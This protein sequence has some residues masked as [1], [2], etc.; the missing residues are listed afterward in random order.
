MVDLDLNAEMAATIGAAVGSINY[1]AT[2][3][4]GTNYMADLLG[5]NVGLGYIAVGAAGVVVIT[6]H[7]GVTEV[8]DG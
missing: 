1:G 5:S 4:L 3:L 7:L 6:E 8:F 2:E